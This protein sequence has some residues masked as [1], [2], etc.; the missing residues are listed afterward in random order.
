MTSKVYFFI[1]FILVTGQLFAQDQKS[2]PAKKFIF[3]VEIGIE[4][5]N[6]ESGGYSGSYLSTTKSGAGVSP[7]TKGGNSLV[8]AFK[9]S[10]ALS[11]RWRIDALAGLTPQRLTFSSES[12]DST[13]SPNPDSTRKQVRMY[14]DLGS[15]ISYQQP[16]FWKVKLAPFI[17]TG[18]MISLGPERASSYTY[19][20]AGLD[21]MI[22][23]FYV[24]SFVRLS[25]DEAD[26]NYPTDLLKPGHRI[27]HYTY[28]PYQTRVSIGYRF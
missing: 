9:T 26:V 19:L 1:F 10:Y 18:Y 4:N 23:K 17:R 2:A 3:S 27:Y 11:S 21:L 14:A 15:G 13:Y 22:G 8:A 6:T 5:T 16:L 7:L 24:S 12:L 28:D 25:L 20:S